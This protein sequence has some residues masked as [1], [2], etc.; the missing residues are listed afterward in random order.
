MEPRLPGRRAPIV[1]G[2]SK[3][4]L[5]LLLLGSVTLVAASSWMWA[6]ADTQDRYPPLLLWAVSI[7]G[8]VFFGVGSMVAAKKLLDRQPGLMLDEQGIWYNTGVGAPREVRW[9][10]VRG[11]EVLDI[12]R[13][14]VLLVLVNNPQELLDQQRGW[15][16]R[17]MRLNLQQYGTPYSISSTV[18]QIDFDELVKT[19]ID[20]YRAGKGAAADTLLK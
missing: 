15:Q 13:T 9:A 7:L 5:L 11:F 12:N 3:R 17:L 16:Q 4:K 18:L 1:V 2:L 14:R 8:N 19:V 6:S 10:N 20:Y